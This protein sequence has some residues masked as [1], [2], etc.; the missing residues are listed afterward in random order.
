MANRN[1]NATQSNRRSRG[2]TRNKEVELNVDEKDINT[3]DLPHV[4]SKFR[5]K[6]ANDPQWYTT[7][8]SAIVRDMANLSFGEVV[9]AEYL[10]RKRRDGFIPLFVD[11]T[12][13]GKTSYVVTPSRLWSAA[14][15]PGILTFHLMPS[16]GVCKD[17]TD[18]P[19]LA[20]QQLFTL[21]RKELRVSQNYDKTDVMMLIVAMNSAYMLLEELVRAYKT[22]GNYNAE[23]RYV[24]QAQLQAM[25][26]NPAL[27]EQLA[28]IKGILDIFSYQIGSINIPDQFTFISRS[29]WLY[30]NIYTDAPSPKA[31]QYIY[32]P[33][34]YY[35]WTEGQEDSPTYLKYVE[36]EQLFTGEPALDNH[37]FMVTETDQIWR[38]I[39]SIMQP[40][41]GSADVGQISSD[42]A[43]AFGDG[44]ILNFR[45]IENTNVGLQPVYSPEVVEQMSNATI[46]PHP[47]KWNETEMPNC[48]IVPELNNLVAGPFLVHQP[49]F[50]GKTILQQYDMAAKTLRKTLLNYRMGVPSPEYNL[51]STRLVTLLSGSDAA[52][53]QSIGQRVESCGTEIC[54]GATFTQMMAGQGSLAGTLTPVT[55]KFYQDVSWVAIAATG[56]DVETADVSMDDET[57]Q[58]LITSICAISAFDNHPTVYNWKVLRTG[59]GG[60]Q[61]SMAFAGTIQDFNIY[62]WL[63]DELVK[64]LNNTALL[65]EFKA[66]DFN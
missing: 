16:I 30:S 13:T 5:G 15:V 17:P 9:G 58:E 65:S 59:T 20:A 21:I 26:Y 38:A 63:P 11:A 27:M 62:T 12:S 45:E 32:A 7:I 56:K 42:I 4:V 1:K 34:G 19:N 39:N 48:N 6:K 29:S 52:N 49:A 28:E 50:Q 8:G 47:A 36:R 22:M 31:Q 23:N 41:L 35:V 64:N 24:P 60:I 61:A 25:G 44:G 18:A 51:V 46:L 33:D 66:K 57:Y 43:R 14:T 37:N 10:Y 3:A 40:I 53:D 54:V 2:K 55:S